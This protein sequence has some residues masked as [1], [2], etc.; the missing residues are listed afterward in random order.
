MRVLGLSH[1]SGLRWFALL[2]GLTVGFVVA[3]APAQDAVGAQ[4]PSA[5]FSRADL[6]LRTPIARLERYSVSARVRP[7]LLFWIGREDV[8]SAEVSWRRGTPPRR[9][10]EFLIG[11]NPEHAPRRL[12]RWGFISEEVDDRGA[13]V[14]G[15]MRESKEQTLEEADAE[16]SRQ[17]DSGVFKAVQT[18]FEAH[19]AVTRTMTVRAPGHL[20][21]RDLDA[22]LQL[23]AVRQ[24]T[25]LRSAIPPSVLPGFLVALDDLLRTSSA[26]CSPER[27][28]PRRPVPTSYFYRQAFY[29]LVL[30]SCARQAEWRGK[31]ATFTDLVDGRFQIRNRTT[32]H[33]TEFRVVYGAS[34]HLAGIPVRAVFRPQWSIEIE[35]VLVERDPHEA[36]VTPPRLVAG[37]NP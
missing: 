32:G 22:V 6:A 15:V 36:G 25:V 21:Y 37:V 3:P 35:L 33:K 10:I 12:N 14:I 5:S 16:T 31:A 2:T 8:G 23:V 30:T 29:D 20:T 4:G 26:S 18:T 9:A 1:L 34:G 24:A 19:E 28:Q 13:D 7:L 17:T 11:T 27:G